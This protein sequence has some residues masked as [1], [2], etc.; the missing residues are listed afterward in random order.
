MMTSNDDSQDDSGSN[1]PAIPIEQP[2]TSSNQSSCCMQQLVLPATSPFMTSHISYND[3]RSICSA[4]IDTMVTGRTMTSTSRRDL[5]DLF[6]NLLD[7]KSVEEEDCDGES[8]ESNDEESTTMSS[9]LPDDAACHIY[10]L[11]ME[12]IPEACSEQNSRLSSKDC[13]RDR[14]DKRR[15]RTISPDKEKNSAVHPRDC[16]DRPEEVYIETFSNQ[17]FDGTRSEKSASSSRRYRTSGSITRRSVISGDA[18]LSGSAVTT[19]NGVSNILQ[20]M[21]LGKWEEDGGKGFNKS[22]VPSLETLLGGDELEGNTSANLKK[23]K[24][25]RR[26]RMIHLRAG[27]IM[28]FL[29][30]LSF[31]AVQL[32]AIAQ[33]DLYLRRGVQN[34]GVADED[35]LRS[36]YQKER[37]GSLR[38][39]PKIPRTLDEFANPI[40]ASNGSDIPKSEVQRKILVVEEVTVDVSKSDLIEHGG[41][42]IA[43]DMTTGNVANSDL[44]EKDAAKGTAVEIEALFTNESDTAKL[45]PNTMESI[46]K[47]IEDGSI[48]VVNG[49]VDNLSNIGSDNQGGMNS[50]LSKMDAAAVG[51][52][53]ASHLYGYEN[54]SDIQ[55]LDVE[56]KD[57][58]FFWNIPLSG[59]EKVK[60]ILKS[61]MLTVIASEA[62]GISDEHTSETFLK[63]FDLQGRKFVNVDV[64]SKE[65][66][67]R[68]KSRALTQSGM[69][70]VII[71]PLFHDAM[72]LFDEK[73]HGRAFTILRHPIERA[74]NTYHDLK[75]RNHPIVSKMTI[76]QYAISPQIENNWMV[77]YLT[78]KIQGEINP[79][80]L[81]LAKKILQTKF[82]V[83][84]DDRNNESVE[85]MKD[86][87]LFQSDP[88]IS[89][90]C[91]DNILHQGSIYSDYTVKDGTPTWTL[92]EWQ[93]R[94]DLELYIY[95]QY[96]FSL[97]G[98]QFFDSGRAQ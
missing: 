36:H 39:V 80:D 66:I 78:G 76:A 49:P 67:E 38:G 21:G 63:T 42:N 88:S 59:G 47:T 11:P 6:E 17:S 33:H 92:L 65:G 40:H 96:L 8:I 20:S 97:Q 86:Y 94:F 5:D 25:Q 95:G 55:T 16:D 77:R 56:H 91:T 90:E 7:N 48:N 87:F 75:R 71:S 2:S 12:I 29:I 83:G 50:V 30:S 58:P 61:C 62:G 15:L 35:T 46:L 26:K 3:D 32:S 70:E 24:R 41:T 98:T 60:E 79:Q 53:E 73:H 10:T 84:L 18:S 74:I 34:Q 13:N 51:I 72:T 14:L 89:Q 54:L 28:I 85:R 93:N 82:I 23:T 52:L 57:V 22:N 69:A 4:T 31:F 44:I 27:M 19:D 45:T 43:A 68:A 1:F 81:V 9:I 37:S 64:S